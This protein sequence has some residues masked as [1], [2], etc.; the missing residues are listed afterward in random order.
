MLIKKVGI[1]ANI[2]KEK[3]PACTASLRDWLLARGIVVY[4]E[5]GIAAKIGDD[6]NFFDKHLSTLQNICG[7]ALS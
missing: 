2:A 1:I 7:H 3:S 6:S 4:L 5:E